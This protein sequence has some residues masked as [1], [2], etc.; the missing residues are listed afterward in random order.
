VKLPSLSHASTL[1]L[2]IHL[3]NALSHSLL[4]YR[5]SV[6]SSSAP[7]S[8]TFPQNFS[9]WARAELSH[10]VSSV[11]PLFLPL[12]SHQTLT[13]PLNVTPTTHERAYFPNPSTQ[14]LQS[15]AASAPF[16]PLRLDEGFVLELWSDPSSRCEEGGGSKDATIRLDLVASVAKLV[17]R[18][19]MTAVAWGVA[20]VALVLARQVGSFRT[21]GERVFFFSGV[22]Q[23]D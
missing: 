10:F 23:R 14:Q 15:H 20:V 22:H 21:S 16:L 1:L 2:R 3:P 13:S 7:C 9:L 12:L 6:E 17:L 4:V 18:Y 19:R 8:G 11:P 5:I